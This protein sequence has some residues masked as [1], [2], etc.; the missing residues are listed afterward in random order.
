M[1]RRGNAAVIVLI[2]LILVSLCA[3][4]GGF[5]LLQKERVKSLDLEQRLEDL[6]VKQ[7]STE[8]KLR[9]S[10]KLISEMQFKLQDA[11]SQ[12]DVLGSELQ[13]EKAAKEQAVAKMEALSKRGD[14]R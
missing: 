7:R 5:Y 1:G 9:E 11:K 14:E 13:Q 4:G 10:E 12:I 2:V 8:A 6:N 3:A